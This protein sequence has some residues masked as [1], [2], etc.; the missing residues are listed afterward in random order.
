MLFYSSFRLRFKYRP[1][2]ILGER[3]LCPASPSAPT[4]RPKLGPFRSF[5]RSTCFGCS[6]CCSSD[7]VDEEEVDVDVE[8]ELDSLR[9][10]LSSSTDFALND[11]LPL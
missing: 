11:L 8:D 6:F 5:R 10:P 9:R 3:Y 2:S 7:D 4:F 1:S